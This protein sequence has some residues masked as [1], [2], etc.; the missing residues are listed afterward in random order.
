MEFAYGRMKGT[1]VREGQEDEEKEEGAKKELF[2]T[3]LSR[4]I[5]RRI[6]I[7]GDIRYSGEITL[8]KVR[9][10]KIEPQLFKIRRRRRRRRRGRRRRA[11]PR[12]RVRREG[13]DNV[14]SARSWNVCE[15]SLAHVRTDTR[16]YVDRETKGQGVTGCTAERG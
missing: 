14:A 5:R 1:S 4:W 2:P 12:R 16:T 9:F 3:S 8:A 15:F 6:S 7:S 11:A 13:V 10:A